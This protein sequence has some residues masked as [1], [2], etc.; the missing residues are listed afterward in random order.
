MI[1]Q[2]ARRSRCVTQSRPSWLK[3]G[4]PDPWI[5]RARHIVAVRRDTG[6]A[7]CRAIA[8]GGRRRR[9]ARG[10]ACHRRDRCLGGFPGLRDSPRPAAVRARGERTP[11]ERPLVGAAGPPGRRSGWPDRARLA[12]TRG[13]QCRMPMRSRRGRGSR[14]TSLAGGRRWG[15]HRG[16]DRGTGPRSHEIDSAPVEPRPPTRRRDRAPR[17]TIAGRHLHA[18]QG[19]AQQRTAPA[20]GSGRSSARQVAAPPSWTVT[21]TGERA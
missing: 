2:D 6:Y 21:W 14:R 7:S 1:L 13:S 11:G 4:G 3:T 9:S 17:G 5:E 18:G 12:C 20:S 19:G 16:Q 15:A 10:T 8:V